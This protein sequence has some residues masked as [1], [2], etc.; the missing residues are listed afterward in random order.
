MIGKIINFVQVKNHYPMNNQSIIIVHPVS[1][2]Q[3]TI[4]KAFLEAL[5]I[6]FELAKNDTY[7]PAF[8]EKIMESKK[9]ISEGRFTEVKADN[10]KAFI[11]DL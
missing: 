7:K 3:T 10:L 9:Q 8:V 4:L 6:K 11:D 5:K 1:D 2:E